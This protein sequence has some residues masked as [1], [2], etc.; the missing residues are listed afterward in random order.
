MKL[1]FYGPNFKMRFGIYKE[2]YDSIT[3]YCF[4]I[5]LCSIEIER[6]V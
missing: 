5:W 1:K 4:N 3:Y 2:S 6:Y